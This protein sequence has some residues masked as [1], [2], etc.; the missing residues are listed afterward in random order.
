MGVQKDENSN[1]NEA[2]LNSKT[3]GKKGY[4]VAKESVN[5]LK[6][7]VMFASNQLSDNISSLQN[8]NYF[9]NNVYR[10]LSSQLDDIRL[11]FE[12]LPEKLKEDINGV[13]KDRFSI[14]LFG[15]TM[16]GK[17]TLMEVLTHG[18]GSSIGKGAQRT[19]RDVRTYR[20][21]NL[22]VTDVPGIAAFEGEEDESVAFEAAKKSDLILFLI[23]DD[24]PQANE[25]ECLNNIL[26]LGK[27]VI[28]LINV[29][30]NIA[31]VEDY[32]LFKRDLDKKMDPSR[33]QKIK[34]QFFDFG[35]SYGQDWH[36]I[37]FAYVHLKSAFLSQQPEYDS[38]SEELYYLSRFNYIDRLIVEEVISNGSF[39]KF[40]AYVDLVTVPVMDS[41]ET[42]FK[43]SSMNSL[44]GR[45][46]VGKKRKFKSWIDDFES[47]GNNKIES[48]IVRISSELKQEISAFAEDNYDNPQASKEW[49]SLIENYQIEH[50]A[51]NLL[52]QLNEE[53]KDELNEISREIKTELNF[54]HTVISDKSSNMHTIIDGKKIWNWTTGLLSGGLTIA[55]LFISG[56]VGWIGL[57]VGVLGFL[58]SFLFGDKEKKVRRAREKLELKLNKHID[59]FLVKLSGQ[60]KKTFRQSI[61]EDQLYSMNTTIDKVI[62][63]LFV[64][65][66]TQQEL[67]ISLNNKLKEINFELTSEGL[68]HSG[69]EGLEYHIN[70]VARIPGY[71]MMLVVDGGKRFPDDAKRTL[72]NLFKEKVWFAF[73][74]ESKIS[75]ISQAVGRGLKR[76]NISIEK[77]KGVDRIA[78]IPIEDEL[79]SVSKNRMRLA[80]QFTGLIFMR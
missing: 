40:K 28:C 14:T 48:F 77:I 55:G 67:A 12:I 6:K 36:K 7:V 69:F 41:L 49:H 68:K 29:K 52:K 56:P 65:S 35:N 4:K 61:L 9:D 72:S 80:Q 64:L 22:Y 62:D 20:Y 54:I 30:A 45:A 76:S 25:A 18:K 42:L 58:G 78:H 71:A 13:E 66:E 3:Y 26:A 75:M 32:K 38:I 33:L 39:Y 74:N 1:L 15:R 27:P 79:D 70:E 17:S 73:S 24:A 59:K 63:S 11:N 46:L 8:S 10:N 50:R 21:K 47:S 37:R 43:Q 44:Q 51:E 5:L 31:S 60:M 23:T 53:S 57:G 19:T 16:A 2:I 34:Q